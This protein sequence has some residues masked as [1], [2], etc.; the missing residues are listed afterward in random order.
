MRQ[1]QQHVC[2]G[3]PQMMSIV[4]LIPGGPPSV[5]WEG[6]CALSSSC[7]RYVQLGLVHAPR[8]LQLSINTC[9]L[10]LNHAGTVRGSRSYHIYRIIP[11]G[12]AASRIDG[13]PI[14][15][16]ATTSS[17]N[18]KTGNMVQAW[19]LRRD[20]PPIYAVATPV[21]VIVFPDDIA[22]V[23]APGAFV[24]PDPPRSRRCRCR[25]PTACIRIRESSSV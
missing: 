6:G 11:R 8:A 19:I 1:G 23:D 2:I 4:N 12:L 17:N 20:V 18:E 21:T 10:A 3:A 14:V 24:K 13:S 25:T 15:V 9:Q 7:L 5:P 16:V 22:T